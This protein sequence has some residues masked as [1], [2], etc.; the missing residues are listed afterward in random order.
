MRYINQNENKE[1]YVE[2]TR[3]EKL[4]EMKK[5]RIRTLAFSA[6]AVTV[7][8]ISVLAGM[9]NAPE[10]SEEAA[11]LSGYAYDP[12]ENNEEAEA[13]S[14]DEKQLTHTK[15]ELGISIPD[16]SL[17][18]TAPKGRTASAARVSAG[19]SLESAP[20]N[21]D[22]IIK[23]DGETYNVTAGGTVEDALEKTGI[24][25]NK[26]DIVTPSLDTPLTDNTVITVQRVT[27]HRVKT[28]L[29]IPYD[30]DY[31]EDD[32]VY[33]GTEYTI[34]DG[35]DG[36][37]IREYRVKRIDGKDVSTKLLSETT[38]SEPVNEII[39]RGTKPYD[40]ESDTLP[41]TESYNTEKFVDYSN[42]EST[43]AVYDGEGIH[44]SLVG[45]VSQF[46]VPDDLYLDENNAPLKYSYTLHGK[47][48]AYTA[49]E[50]ALMSTG[51][52]VEQGYVAV[53][54]EIIPYGSKLYIVADDGEVY[55]YAVAGDTGGSVSKNHIIV[56][57]F[58]W[59][60]DECMQWGAKDVTIYVLE[61]DDSEPV[62]KYIPDSDDDD[63]DEYDANDTDNE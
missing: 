59:S 25:L 9:A 21:Y 19:R 63:S 60:Y 14:K 7:F 29:K 1:E 45:S 5:R 20:A 30:I 8:C 4:A 22:V 31:Y 48:C 55:G 51:K 49:E 40:P 27:Y 32:T 36:K 62:V 52:A 12:G 41:D 24:E 46:E 34:V 18:E 61:D 15:E 35:V 53:N 3:S 50:G 56:D 43:L 38:D 58:M 11:D 37:I 47:S 2:L 44:A 26:K 16:A 6:G 33:E 13:G 42:S 54:P 57:L 23:A 39:C 10:A 28:S 17:P